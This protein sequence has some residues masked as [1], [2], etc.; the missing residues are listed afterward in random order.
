MAVQEFLSAFGQ[1]SDIMDRRRSRKNQEAEAEALRQ[2]REKQMAQEAE[3]ADKEQ[4]FKQ[5]E[6]QG[7]YGLLLP[8][9]ERFEQIPGFQKPETE[10]DKLG[11]ALKGLQ[12]QKAQQDIEQNKRQAKEA[13][14]GKDS[15]RLA[16][17]FLKRMQSAEGSYGGLLKE[18]YDPTSLSSRA[19]SLSIFP[20]AFK[21]SKT[22]QAEQA[23][24][25]FIAAV[26][27]KESGAAISPSEYEE[28]GK[29]YFPRAGDTPDVL[30]QKE[31]ARRDVM[32]GMKLQAGPAAGLLDSSPV[33]AKEP[34][35]LIDQASAQE[36]TIGGQKYIKVKGGWQRAK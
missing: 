4:L 30:A 32:E 9:Q 27:R 34:K 29:I 17:T 19:Q 12:I 36:K 2:F 24:K 15:E 20:E 11:A 23:E 8:G 22:K 31:Q 3:K 10:M 33:V 7:R 35:G 5:A 13:S 14:M 18:G 25:N 6:L 26:L 28:A 1:V 21:G 16:A